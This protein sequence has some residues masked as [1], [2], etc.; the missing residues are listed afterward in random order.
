MKHIKEYNISKVDELS[1]YLQEYFDRYYIKEYKP[2]LQQQ[3][4]PSWWYIIDSN[5]NPHITIT[6]PHDI[7]KKLR[8]DLERDFESIQKRIR[9]KIEIKC[10]EVRGD[11][12]DISIYLQRTEGGQYI[13]IS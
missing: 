8:K 9:M 5:H 4:H 7:Y 11:I 1:D 12:S 3:Q 6:T 13:P 10:Y 2:G